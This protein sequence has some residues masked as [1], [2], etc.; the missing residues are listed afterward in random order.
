M[1]AL[2]TS[3]IDG[4]FGNL[5][6]V[7]NNDCHNAPNIQQIYGLQFSSKGILFRTTE[8]TTL[9]LPNN[10]DKQTK[11]F[12]IAS[13]TVYFD[14]YTAYTNLMVA[15]QQRAMQEQQMQQQDQFGTQMYGFQPMFRYI[16]IINLK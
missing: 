12:L 6:S 5:Y 11:E 16:N 8:T 13:T 9:N 3:S 15:K 7:A 14:W 1:L 4:Q 2:K 10:L